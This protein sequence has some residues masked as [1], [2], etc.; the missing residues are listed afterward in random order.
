VSPER[1]LNETH[2]RVDE[3]LSI[4]ED[5]LSFAERAKSEFENGDI[6]KKR[7]ILR[8][9]GSNLTLKDKMLSVSL[10]ESLERLETAAPTARDISE[11]FEPQNSAENAQDLGEIYSQNP[12][13]LRWVEDV[14]TLCLLPAN[15][16][17]P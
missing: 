11:R 1:T 16:N 5:H 10:P 6:A 12:T 15:D 3:W 4:V 14:R 13:L 8:G 2:R 9:L 17:R 7:D